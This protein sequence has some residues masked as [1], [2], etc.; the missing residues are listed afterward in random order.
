LAITTNDG[1][2]G[3]DGCTSNCFSSEK[4]FWRRLYSAWV[5]EMGPKAVHISISGI[6]AHMF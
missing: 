6:L 3:G 1:A 4:V 2:R 5:F